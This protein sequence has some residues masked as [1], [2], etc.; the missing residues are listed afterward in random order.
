[1][2]DKSFRLKLFT[3]S[4][5][6]TSMTSSYDHSS[7]LPIDANLRYSVLSMWFRDGIPVERLPYDSVWLTFGN[8]RNKM[9]NELSQGLW[10]TLGDFCQ[11]TPV[12]KQ[13]ETASSLPLQRWAFN[14]RT[15]Y[16]PGTVLASSAD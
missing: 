8:W 2:V 9:K 7:I 1:M 16:G 3:I 5:L 12:G 14:W 13:M 6:L 4:T 15:A 10:I 11:P